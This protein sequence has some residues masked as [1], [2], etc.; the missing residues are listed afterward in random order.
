[1]ET[2]PQA[3]TSYLV[4]V[5][6]EPGTEEGPRF[7]LRDLRTGEERFMGDGSRIAELLTAGLDDSG[8]SATSESALGRKRDTA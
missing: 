5:W 6:R 3:S 1:M 4:R 8:K 7:F 2:T